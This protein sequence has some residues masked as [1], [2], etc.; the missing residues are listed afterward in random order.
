MNER[1]LKYLIKQAKKL[2]DKI[3]EAFQSNDEYRF[4]NA[5]FNAH[6]NIN[7]AVIDLTHC[8]D[9]VKEKY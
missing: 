8:Q 7:A 3:L 9:L 1:E 2:D 5:L 4:Y 6:N